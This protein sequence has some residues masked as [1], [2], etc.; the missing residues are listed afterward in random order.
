M[1]V[2]KWVDKSQTQSANC[3]FVDLSKANCKVWGPHNIFSFFD[4]VLLQESVYS[5][6]IVVFISR[7]GK[8]SRQK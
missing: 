3:S 4:N 6:K 8:F 5:E 7:T 2:Q 1:R